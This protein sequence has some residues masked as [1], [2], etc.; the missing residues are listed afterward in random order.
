M[1]TNIYTLV[2][3]KENKFKGKKFFLT[4]MPFNLKN[5]KKFK[6]T[7]NVNFTNNILNKSK[8]NILIIDVSNLYQ[9]T[10][11]YFIYDDYSIFYKIDIY[12]LKKDFGGLFFINQNFTKNLFEFKYLWFFSEKNFSGF[13]LNLNLIL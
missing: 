6:F 11:K 2:P 4:N 13:L 1:K 7:D 5:T 12:Q 9:F 8:N 10:N 3:D